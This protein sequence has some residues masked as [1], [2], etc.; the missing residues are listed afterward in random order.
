MNVVSDKNF[1]EQLNTKT[2][3][4]NA[5]STIQALTDPVHLEKS[6]SDL[7]D[8]IIQV[9]EAGMRDGS[10]IPATAIITTVTVTDST[11]TILLAPSKGEVHQFLG[12]SAY[13]DGGSGSRTYNMHLGDANGEL[14]Y[15]Y[16][17]S[18]TDSG[19]LLSGDSNYPGF[20][21]FL[22]EGMSLQVTTTGTFDSSKWSLATIRVR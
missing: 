16:Y 6:N 12:I 4:D 9:N 15:F 5:A 2:L 3:G 18:T 22:D 11:R 21:L 8:S 19:V 20:P 14:V 1:F 7:L 13:T 10:P 17:T